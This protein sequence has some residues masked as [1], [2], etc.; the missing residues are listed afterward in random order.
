MTT[1]NLLK[2][3]RLAGAVLRNVGGAFAFLTT[4]ASFVFI[5]LIIVGVVS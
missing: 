4:L 5:G 2:S 3:E 1:S